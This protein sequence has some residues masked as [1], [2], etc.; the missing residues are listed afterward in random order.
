MARVLELDEICDRALRMI[1]ATAIRSSGSRPEELT[2]ARYWLDMLVAHVCATRRIWWLIPADVTFPLVAGQAD[3]DLGTVLRPNAPDGVQFV[4]S[5][6]LVDLNQHRDVRELGL[7]RR[8]EWEE[9]G[10]RDGNLGVPEVALVDHT[11]DDPVMHLHPTPRNTPPYGVR[12]TFQS[13]S[14]DLTKNVGRDYTYRIRRSWNMYLVTA[15]AAKLANG[16]VRKAPADEVADLDRKAANLLWEISAYDDEQT[17]G[18][19]RVAYND[20]I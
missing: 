20:G 11:V 10:Q 16:P 15:L 18:D 1:G 5:A 12:L 4:V 13:Y 8:S 2:E 9:I 19:R 3:Y 7:L 6:V 14:S 17:G